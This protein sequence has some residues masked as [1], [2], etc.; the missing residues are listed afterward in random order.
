[1]AKTKIEDPITEE[2][3]ES[4]ERVYF[5]VLNLLAGSIK[6]E[7]EIERKIEQYLKKEKLETED[8]W[9][10]KYAVIKRLKELG[11]YDD[12]KFTKEFLDNILLSS[13]P[14]SR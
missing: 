12:N 5:K 13:R 10:V 3:K 1:M 9:D 2:L 8:H 6:S 4:L 11:H 7:R 14:R